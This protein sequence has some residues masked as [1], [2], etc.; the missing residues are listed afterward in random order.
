MPG[1]KSL[2]ISMNWLFSLVLT[3]HVLVAL[4]I[5][6]LVLMQ[7]GKGADMGAAFG[8]GASGS[9]FGSSGS[10][11]FLSRSTGVLAAVFFVT[12]LVLAHVASSAPKTSGSVM[13]EAVQS[14]PVS[15]PVS[16][17]DVPQTPVQSGSKEKEIPR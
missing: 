17:S 4:A 12:S 11:N 13:Q 9:V 15:E 5:I 2:N 14:A 8:S 3:V 7:H 6:G 16:G 10:A 1:G